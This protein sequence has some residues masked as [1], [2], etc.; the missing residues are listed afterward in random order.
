MK[1]KRCGCEHI[2][3]CGKRKGRQCYLCRNCGH[4]FVSVSGRHT[5]QEKQC[6][7]L[8][9]CLGLSFTAI[10]GV[11]SVHPSTILRWVC[12]YAKDNCG[13]PVPQGEIVIELDEMW[14][15]LRSKKTK[16]WIWKAYC[17]STRELI[18]W[19]LG[20]RSEHVHVFA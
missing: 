6:A 12:K 17:R 1:C 15:F 19:E 16:V 7:V 3:K 13:K 14:H 8:L 11:L 4:Q 5:L 10:A 2:V 9:Y 20:D 18:D